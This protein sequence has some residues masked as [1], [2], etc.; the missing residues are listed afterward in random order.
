MQ[1][2]HG[3]YIKYCK[4]RGSERNFFKV[5]LL[6]EYTARPFGC[7]SFGLSH[8]SA[9]TCDEA[10]LKGGKTDRMETTGGVSNL[11]LQLCN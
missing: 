1:I 11:T 10:A 6:Q 5:L 4:V 3:L 2:F 7:S 8:A 9:I